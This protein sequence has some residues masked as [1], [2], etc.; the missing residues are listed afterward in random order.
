MEVCL[1]F[2]DCFYYYYYLELGAEDYEFLLFDS[3]SSYVDKL[4]LRNCMKLFSIE[5]EY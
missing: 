1:G 3:S 4:Y 5:L 2:F